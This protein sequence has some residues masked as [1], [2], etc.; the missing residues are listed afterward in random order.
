MCIPFLQEELIYRVTHLHANQGWVDFDLGCSTILPS[1][2]AA[3]AKF[4]PAQAESAESG[5]VKI[6]VNPTQVRQEMGHPIPELPHAHLKH[7]HERRVQVEDEA[8]VLEL[9]VPENVERLARRVQLE[10]AEELRLVDDHDVLSAVDVSQPFLDGIERE[11]RGVVLV[12]VPVCDV[13]LDA[14]SYK[15]VNVLFPAI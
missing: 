4:P 9:V 13:L 12:P 11:M 14:L 8:A 7:W 15:V 1:C 10:V 6:Q 5:T 2:S 3:F